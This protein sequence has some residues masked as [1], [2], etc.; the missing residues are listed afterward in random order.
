MEKNIIYT[1]YTIYQHVW[2]VDRY[3]IKHRCSQYGNGDSEHKDIRMMPREC[4]ISGIMIHDIEGN[5]L[6][7]VTPVKCTEAESDGYHSHYHE[8]GFYAD[9]IF[10]TYE[11]AKESLERFPDGIVIDTLD[12]VK[13]N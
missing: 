7:Y 5:H 3:D 11:D 6:Y 9:K 12:E 2:I 8:Q 4:F 13:K 1:D 10:G